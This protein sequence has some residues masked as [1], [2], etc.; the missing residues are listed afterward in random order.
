MSDNQNIAYTAG[1]NSSQALTDAYNSNAVQ[2]FGGL[3]KDFFNSVSG[4]IGKGVDFQTGFFSQYMDEDFA[5]VAA[6]VTTL[7]TAGY[8]SSGQGIY[9]VGLMG[10]ALGALY[11]SSDNISPD[12]TVGKATNFLFGDFVGIYDKWQEGCYDTPEASAPAPVMG[13]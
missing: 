13:G 10:V 11:N 5:K 9:G 3:I 8:L 4:F 6:T 2:G 7:A 1:E 12:S